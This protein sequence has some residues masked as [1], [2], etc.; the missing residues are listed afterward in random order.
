[1]KFYIDAIKMVSKHCVMISNQIEQLADLQERLFK[2]MLANENQVFDKT[3]G[4]SAT[5]NPYYPKGNFRKEIQD[6]IKQKKFFAGTYP[7]I[8]R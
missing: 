1:V 5:Q 8:M 2:Q 3:M 7:N 4:G 6:A